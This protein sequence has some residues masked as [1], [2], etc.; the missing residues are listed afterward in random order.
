MPTP[1]RSI[2]VRRR[3]R[4]A[5]AALPLAALVTLAAPAFGQTLVWEDEFDGDALDAASWTALL[6]RGPEYGLPV[7]WGNNELQYYT[8]RPENIAV[9]GGL[10]RIIARAESYQ[11]ASYTSARLRT[12]FKR[13]FRYGRFEGRMKLPSGQGIW[14]AFWMLD[15]NSPYGGWAASGEIDI[16]ESVNEADRIYGTIHY[17]G[18]FPGNQYKGSEYEPGTDFSEDFH[19]YAI[20]WLPDEIRWFVDDVQ[21]GS[22]SR[23]QW[24]SA[25]APDNPRAPFD[26]DF[27]LLMNVAVGGNFPG[28]PNG[29]VGFPMELV[30]DWVR[31]YELE[32]QSPFPGAPLAIPGVVEAEDFDLGGQ[33][34]AYHDTEAQNLGGAYRPGEGV[35]L[36]VDIGGGFNVGFIRAGEWIEYAIDVAQPGHYEVRTRCA[37]A[38]TGGSFRLEFDG[39]DT[40]GGILVPPTGGWQVWTSVPAVV[41]V[42]QAEVLRFVN[43]SGDESQYNVS[44]FEFTFLAAPGDVDGSGAIDVED[45]YALEENDGPYLDVDLNGTNGDAAD[46]TALR[47]ILRAAEIDGL[48]LQ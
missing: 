36:E 31:V 1:R 41:A 37:S 6:G 15:T 46:R 7:G 2:R 45:L 35:D 48:E 21:Y 20:E 24:F 30:V 23:D 12:K 10:L 18:E 40:S 39:V 8:A 32:L 42:P 34:I 9:G 13:D 26:V 47:A 19:V 38:V 29:D 43:D 14:P 25:N 28:E 33:S 16:M 11:G 22:L 3:P 44:S 27:H 4:R 5:T 17:G